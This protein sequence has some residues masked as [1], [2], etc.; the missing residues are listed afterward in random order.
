MPSQDPKE[1]GGGAARVV[2]YRDVT[3]GDVAAYRPQRLPDS[4]PYASADGYEISVAADPRPLTTGAIQTLTFEIKKGDQ[5]VTD[6]ERYLGAL[7]HVV[8]LH[9]SDL[10]Y[11][12]THPSPEQTMGKQT[13][14][15]P[16]HVTFLSEGRYKAIFQFQKNGSVTT[17]EFV[18]DVARGSSRALS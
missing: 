4:T 3:V 6:L 18:F 12:H 1:P 15:L 5:P 8:I 17:V 10:E 2:A 14:R 13:G 16:F 9:E 11:I 7:G